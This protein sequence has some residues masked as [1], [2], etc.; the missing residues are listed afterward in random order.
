MKLAAMLV[1]V[2]ACAGAQAP[3]G[4]DE[5]SELGGAR[6]HGDPA[7]SACETYR[8]CGTGLS[9]VAGACT[10]P[11]SAPIA[12]GNQPVLDAMQV[13]TVVWPGDEAVGADVDRFTGA[14]LASDAWLAAVGEY[15]IG[16]GAAH[17]VIVLGEAP[18]ATIVDTDGSF[19]GQRI[20]GVIG[21]TT[22]AGAVV[23][24]PSRNTVFLFVVPRATHAPGGY[25]H[26]ETAGQLMSASGGWLYV[27]YI[28]VRQDHVGFVS[29]RDYLTWSTSHELVETATDPRSQLGG[30]Y[31]SPWLGYLGEVGDL[32]N[33]IPVPAVLGGTTYAITRTYSA[34]NAAERDVDPCVPALPGD[35][36]NIALRPGRLGVPASGARIRLVPFSYG[37]AHPLAWHLYPG[38]GFGVAPDHG[39]NRPGDDIIVTVTR[40]SDAVAPQPLQVWIDDPEH[41]DIPAQEWFGALTIPGT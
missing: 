34:A 29:D 16:A 12:T 30:G 13:Y 15:G 28:T 20:R 9:C 1:L 10:P 5:T 24:A 39:T 2:A 14:L 22:T 36:S 6:P 23:P 37:T 35:Y 38:P 8:T 18:P 7:G 17:G 3:D 26:S 41:P 21:A 11:A 33:D 32:C 31:T 40:T 4:D 19:Y 27:P 25:Y